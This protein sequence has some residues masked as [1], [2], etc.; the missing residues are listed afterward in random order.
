MVVGFTGTRRGMTAAQLTAVAGLLDTLKP[1]AAHHGDCLGA[2]ADFHR[3]CVSRQIPVVIHPPANA[4]WRAFCHG[5]LVKVLPAKDYLERNRD[6]VAAGDVLIATPAGPEML[7]S[8]TWST[9]RYAKKNG[10]P[11]FLVLPDGNVVRLCQGHEG[12]STQPRLF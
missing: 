2:D 10:R 1:V 5:H 12:T 4:G 9:V 3:L 6:I 11:V 8:G 7:R